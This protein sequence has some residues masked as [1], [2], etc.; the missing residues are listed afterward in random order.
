MTQHPLSGFVEAVLLAAGRPV[1]VEQLLELFDEGQRPP[2]E[3]VTAA[4]AELQHSYASRGV[5][6]RQVAS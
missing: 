2:A 4:L 5:E 6:L 3:E 1:S